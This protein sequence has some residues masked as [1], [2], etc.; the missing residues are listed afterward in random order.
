M[1]PF[2]HVVLRYLLISL[3]KNGSPFLRFQKKPDVSIFV[4]FQGQLSSVDKMWGYHHFLY[5]DS[6][7]P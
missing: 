2:Y 1:L 6:N 7:S 4:E 3:Y 5:V